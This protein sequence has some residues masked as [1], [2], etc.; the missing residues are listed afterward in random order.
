MRMIPSGTVCCLAC[1]LRRQPAPDRLA[2]LAILLP[3]I[4]ALGCS[5]GSLPPIPEPSLD[6]FAVAVQD[7][8]RSA[9]ADSEADPLGAETVGRLGRVLYA[10][11]QYRAAA[12]SFERCRSLE[13]DAFQWAYLLGVARAEVG[14]VDEARASFEEAAGMRPGDLPTALRLADL[15]ERSG[16]AIRAQTILDD[17][18]RRSPGIAAVHYRLGRL[19]ATDSPSLAVEHLHAALE[20]EP[21]YREALYALASAFR[22]LG[23]DSEAS[24]QLSLYE[25]TDPTPRRHYADPLLEA[26]DSI[27]AGSA[28]DVFNKAY[29]LQQ[30]GDLESARVLFDSVLEIDPN[31][32]QALV[33]LVAVHGQLGD[34]ERATLHYERSIALD[35][36]IAEAHY[37]Y[38]VSRHFAGDY[39]GAFEAFG[40]AIEINPLDA[41][42]HG[43]LGTTLEA[44]G[45]ESEA[46]RHYRNALMHNPSHPMANFHLGRRLA[47]GGRYR[48]SLPYL[49]KAVAT[50]SEGTAL[51]AFLLALVHRQMGQAERSREYAR[52]ALRHA[53]ARG[54]TDLVAQIRAELDP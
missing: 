5:N 45:R 29:A 1:G 43:N 36:S 3:A 8:L 50:E 27:R 51:H 2:C 48:E 19:A 26:M 39:E 37:N 6:G 17:A 52:L 47:D 7:Q 14:Q 35:P 34:H 12:E 10:Y 42:A 15:L 38:G 30:E 25:E 49:E 53:Q 16:D 9:R 46:A 13:P 31:Y 4:L 22:S 41:D 44:M 20:I 33:N 40:K 11:G 18:L 24:E 28:Q 21:D 54:A 32:V 23:R